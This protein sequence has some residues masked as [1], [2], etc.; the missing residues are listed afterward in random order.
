MKPK[1][2]L[3]CP[4]ADFPASFHTTLK[5]LYE[6]DA[7]LLDALTG[8][9]LGDDVSGLF[10]YGKPEASVQSF[11]KGA[12]MDAIAKNIPILA[13]STGA[14]ALNVAFG[15]GGPV[16]TGDNHTPLSNGKRHRTSIFLAPG[17]KTSSTIG[18]SGWLSVRCD[19]GFGIRQSVLADSMMVACISDDRFVEA[20]ESPGHN[21]RIG[22][23]WDLLSDPKLLPRGF[24]NLLLAFIERAS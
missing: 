6:Y 8:E 20:F 23:Q 2:A 11:R 18:G 17:S 5:Q 16:A 19:H 14:H 21:W 22:A 1:I 24:D 9:C 7:Y 4:D 15:G 3:L 12:I 13:S 10:I